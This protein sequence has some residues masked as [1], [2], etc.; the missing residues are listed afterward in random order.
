VLITLQA[1][2][3]LVAVVLFVIATLGVGV[4]RI[5]L[6]AAGLAFLAGGFLAG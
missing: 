3:F 5:N 4:G 6:M 2:L 1:V